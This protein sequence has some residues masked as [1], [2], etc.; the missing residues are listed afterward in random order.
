MSDMSLAKAPTIA[1]LV[2]LNVIGVN[3]IAPVLPSYAAHFSISITVASALVASFAFSRMLLRVPAGRLSD[4]RG[5]RVIC[6]A[7]GV[8]QALG[9]LLAALA[10]GFGLLLVGRMLQGAGSSLFGTSANRFLLVTT[11]REQ[12]GRATAWFQAGILAGNT[13]GPLLGGVVAEVA[14]IWA[15]FWV[16]AALAFGLTVVSLIAIREPERRGAVPT[17]DTAAVSARMLFGMSGF[18]V[19][20]VMAFGLFF[21]RAGA[22][23]VAVPAFG[24]AV[25]SLSPAQI[26]LVV[27]LGSIVSLGL[28][29]PAGRIADKRG[30]RPVAI[31]GVFGL[32][33]AVAALGLTRSFVAFAAVSALTGIGMGLTSV[34]LPTMV[35]DLAP[36]GTEGMASGLF[37]MANDLGW[38]VGPF[39]L[40]A[41]ADR[42]LY[43]TAFVVSGLPLAF[44][45]MWFVFR[46]RSA[47]TAGVARL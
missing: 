36:P 21:V 8:V 15:P 37:R 19:L 26:G 27:S 7:G 6:A 30:R 32:A 33:A 23:N 41:L 11:E 9:A 24:D 3:L 18:P 17:P 46:S 44:G 31:V 40:G 2:S 43:S 10:P 14:G 38:V 45:G 28:L 47:G 20:M 5:S 34:A 4:A 16:Q 35:G 22:F 12:L 29:G 39:V 25:M 42:D 13:I 1:W